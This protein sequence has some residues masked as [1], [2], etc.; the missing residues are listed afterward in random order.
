MESEITVIEAMTMYIL[1]IP[2]GV[3]FWM[4]FA[5]HATSDWKKIEIE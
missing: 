1:S 2:F 3:V 5:W 4:C